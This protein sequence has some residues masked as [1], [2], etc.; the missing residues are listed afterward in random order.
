MNIVHKLVRVDVNFFVNGEKGNNLNLKK[1]IE[2]LRRIY[3]NPRSGP[4]LVILYEQSNQG[5]TNYFSHDIIFLCALGHM[6]W[7][8]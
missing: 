1:N 6:Q 2:Q 3:E 7:T 5:I 8:S 4:K